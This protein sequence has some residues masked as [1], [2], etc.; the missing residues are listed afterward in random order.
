VSVALL[1]GAEA[2]HKPPLPQHSPRRRRKDQTACGIIQTVSWIT[3]SAGGTINAH[4]NF[5]MTL[6]GR[7]PDARGTRSGGRCSA[8]SSK[9]GRHGHEAKS[10]PFSSSGVSQGSGVLPKSPTG[11]FAFIRPGMPLRLAFSSI[12][13]VKQL[14]TYL[15]PM[16]RCAGCTQARKRIC[17]LH[18][19]V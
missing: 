5:P 14:V 9:V 4:E 1:A 13:A 3:K 15:R 18:A 11:A 2:R 19:S 6:I 16:Q 12:T 8:V 7:C 10:L 17:G